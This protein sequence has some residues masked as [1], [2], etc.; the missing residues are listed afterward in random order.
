MISSDENDPDDADDESFEEEEEY[1]DEG[2]ITSR[3]V[4]G[5][6]INNG[7]E[8]SVETVKRRNFAK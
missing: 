7:T 5:R 4:A 6:E 1:N 2:E 8:Q 3:D